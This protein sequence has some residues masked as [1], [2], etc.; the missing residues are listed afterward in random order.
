M[1]LAMKAV[2]K[3]RFTLGRSLRFE[4]FRASLALMLLLM[5]VI[6][7]L[8]LVATLAKIARVSMR[9]LLDKKQVLDQLTSPATMCQKLG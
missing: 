4:R 5:V 8:L 1:T 3:A 9:L 2:V 7:L 6:M